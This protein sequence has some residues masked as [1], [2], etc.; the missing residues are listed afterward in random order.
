[1][2]Q[3]ALNTLVSDLQH[4]I[5]LL[6]LAATIGSAHTPASTSA[7]CTT[8]R[9]VLRKHNTCLVYWTRLQPYKDTAEVCECLS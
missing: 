3:S 9:L 2:L 5:A 7:W 1:M 6:A 8:A 4:S